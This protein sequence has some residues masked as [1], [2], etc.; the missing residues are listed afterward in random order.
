VASNA[1]ARRIICRS[2]LAAAH[3]AARFRLTPSGGSVQQH[4]RTGVSRLPRTLQAPHWPADPLTTAASEIG[5]LLRL[6][7]PFEPIR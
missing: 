3:Q 1:S 6:R 7:L 2:W 4:R 5:I